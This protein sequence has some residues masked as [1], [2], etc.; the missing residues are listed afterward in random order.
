MIKRFPHL[1]LAFAV[2]FSTVFSVVSLDSPSVNAFSGVLPAC[3]GA[4]PTTLAIQAANSSYDP[5]TYQYVVFN[6]ANTY[7]QGSHNMIIIAPTPAAGGT[8]QMWFTTDS[9]GD[10]HLNFAGGIN[11][12]TI[13]ASSGALT[14]IRD[15]G[16]PALAN[17]GEDDTTCISGTHNWSATL[18]TDGTYTGGL[19]IIADTPPPLYA[20]CSALDFACYFGNVMTFFGVVGDFIG[21]F[22]DS[23]N[24]MIT[25]MA[26]SL[27]TGLQ[28]LFVPS[29]GHFGT[30]FNDLSTFFQTKFGFLTYPFTFFPSLF[31]ALSTYDNITSCASSGLGVPS[32][33]D[34]N[35]GTFYGSAV[36]FN[37][38][39][40]EQ[41]LPSLWLLIQLFVSGI[42]VFALMVGVYHKYLSMVKS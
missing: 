6:R 31:G 2:L 15:S 33:C 8:K 5:T 28:A 42:T 38:G 41:T 25:N 3:S 34:P 30:A 4:I 24:T 40:I 11:T 9:E 37:F 13:D 16:S 27:L 10:T 23:I 35:F 39:A 17:S 21:G 32:V 26:E 36:T 19:Y 14:E 29:S 20:T 18:N 22:F 1:F 12:Y 7:Y